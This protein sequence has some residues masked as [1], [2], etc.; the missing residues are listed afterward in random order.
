MAT[1]VLAAGST[2]AMAVLYHPG[3]D[4]SRVYDGTDTRA[5]GL[6]IGAAL[7]MVWPSRRR[8]A[9][10]TREIRRTLDYVGLGGLIVICVLIWRT[11]QYSAFPYRGGMLLLSIATALVIMA[12]VYPGSWLGRI[13]GIRPVRWIGVRSYGIYLWHYPVIVLT[14]VGLQRRFDLPRATVQVTITI[15]LAA[16]SWRL[17]EEPIRQVGRRPAAEVVPWHQRIAAR[18]TWV[19]ST[20]ALGRSGPDVADHRWAGARSLHLPPDRRGLPAQRRGAR[21]GEQTQPIDGSPGHPSPSRVSLSQHPCRP[22]ALDHHHAGEPGHTVHAEISPRRRRRTRQHH[23][24]R[25][26]D[27]L[28]VPVGRPHRGLDIGEPDF[29]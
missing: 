20:A 16:L 22:G 2:I 29:I 13:L 6:L 21:S 24:A 17:V 10:T 28:L 8:R 12:C 5:F 9:G 3:F 25:V 23:P 15:I 19:V 4:P 26:G 18:W 1:L 27:H 11:N 14:T 7:A